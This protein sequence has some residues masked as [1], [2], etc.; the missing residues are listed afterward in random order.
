MAAAMHVAV[1]SAATAAALEAAMVGA[2]MAAVVGAMRRARTT[3]ESTFCARAQR[4]AR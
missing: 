2:A 1:A 4:I 3:R